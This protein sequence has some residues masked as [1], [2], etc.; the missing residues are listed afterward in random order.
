MWINSL[1]LNMSIRRGKKGNSFIRFEKD[2]GKSVQICKTG[3]Q[4]LKL[5][6]L[7]FFSTLTFQ[8]VTFQPSTQS[9]ESGFV[10]VSNTLCAYQ[11]KAALNWREFPV[12]A[13]DVRV[14]GPFDCVWQPQLFP[15]SWASFAYRLFQ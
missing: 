9:D 1:V 15:V 12:P 10:P 6:W 11:G 3:T 2:I 14:P 13:N 5:Q 8:T 7:H 4:E